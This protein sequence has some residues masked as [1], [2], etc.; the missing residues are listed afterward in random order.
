MVESFKFKFKTSYTTLLAANAIAA[1][2]IQNAFI[3][4]RKF[5]TKGGTISDFKR[6]SRNTVEPSAYKRK[7]G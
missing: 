6:E 4:C 1:V 3:C 7:N 5:R 2:R